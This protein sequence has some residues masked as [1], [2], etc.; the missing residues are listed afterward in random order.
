MTKIGPPGSRATERRRRTTETFVVVHQHEDLVDTPADMV[1]DR[2]HE[3]N[4]V[5]VATQVALKWE[6][7]PLTTGSLPN[8]WLQTPTIILVPKF[9]SDRGP[10]SQH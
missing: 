1:D 4:D 9:L 2:V 8:P 3:A 7:P 6:G 5:L 10:V